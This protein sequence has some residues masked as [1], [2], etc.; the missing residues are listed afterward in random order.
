MSFLNKSV[1]YSQTSLLKT[2]ILKPL[3][4]TYNGFISDVNM[5]NKDVNTGISYD[6]LIANNDNKYYLLVTKKA[7]LEQR[8]ANYNILY[9]FP[10]NLNY[11]KHITSLQNNIVSDFYMEIDQTF[12]DEI[13]LEGYLYKHDDKYSYLVTDLLVKNKNIVTVSYGLRLTLLNELLTKIGFE[14][15]RNLNNHMT[16]NLHPVFNMENEGLVKIFK[17]NFVYKN[18]LCSL[19]RVSGNKKTR[20]VENKNS[21][22]ETKWIETTKYTDVYNVYDMKTNNFQGILY[23]KGIQQSKMI[24]ESFTDSDCSR[25]SL[26][27]KWNNIF[28]KWEP[29]YNNI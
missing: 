28:K 21:E 11:N 25:I 10:D 17:S 3:L 6:Y 2:S 26:M 4:E 20:Y 12:D 9:L 13:L 18:E 22:N 1:N 19:E 24:K 8:S 23:V 29:V 5:N 15:L 7:L 14:K 27:C 16:I